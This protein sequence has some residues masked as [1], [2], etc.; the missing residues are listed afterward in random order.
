[1]NETP[2]LPLYNDFTSERAKKLR[3]EKASSNVVF[4]KWTWYVLHVTKKPH[5]FQAG[6]MLGFRIF[7]TFSYYGSVISLCVVL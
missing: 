4:I 7:I 1:M 2:D 5:L 6:Q 3:Y